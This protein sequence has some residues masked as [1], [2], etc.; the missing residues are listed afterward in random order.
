MEKQY[1]GTPKTLG[2]PPP[3]HTHRYRDRDSEKEKTK[4]NPTRDEKVDVIEIPIK[5]RKPLVKPLKTD[6]PTNCEF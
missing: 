1:L 4:I 2:S 3:R 5:S 6:I